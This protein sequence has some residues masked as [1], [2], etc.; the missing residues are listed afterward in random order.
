MTSNNNQRQKIY[1]TRF[2]EYVHKKDPIIRDDYYTVLNPGA[3]VTFQQNT[4][5][6]KF[7]F[8]SEEVQFIKKLAPAIT[9]TPEGHLQLPMAFR[10]GHPT[11]PDNRS[12]V[13]QRTMNS[14]KTVVSKPQMIKG[15]M[16]Q[17]AK[18]LNCSELK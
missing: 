18:N 11:M 2:S 10:N 9:T 15:C 5:D 14:L 1:W 6:E 13:F 7:A 4:E 16:D 3:E 8:S 17:M 12:A